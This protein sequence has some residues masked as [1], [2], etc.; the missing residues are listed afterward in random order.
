LTLG[1]NIAD[2]GGLS[3]SYD[4]FKLAQARDN[5]NTKSQIDGLTPDQRFFV[6]FA[7]VWRRN[8]RPE[9]LKRRLNVDPH[10]PAQ[11]RAI[12]A[13]SNMQP[14]AEA[15]SCKAG[16]AMVRSGDKLVNIW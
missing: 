3:V 5:Q 9:E 2:L 4:A 11:F 15:F 1:E 16:D 13:P 6:N 12:G 10:A 7:Q 8:F 14:F